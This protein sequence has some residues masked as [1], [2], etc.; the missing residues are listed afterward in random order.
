MPIPLELL[1]GDLLYNGTLDV[2]NPVKQAKY[3]QLNSEWE[4]NNATSSSGT[5]AGSITPFT[6]DQKAAET[7]AME[8][9][10]PYYEKLL[11]IYNGD[12]NLA[13]KRMEEDY[14]RG[15]RYKQEDTATGMGD[16][17]ATKEERA[18]KFQI[19]LGDLDQEMNTRGLYTSG[20][21]TQEREQAT[22]DETRQK[23]LL[24]NQARDLA[25]FEK[26]YVEGA[27]VEKQR[28]L[29][30]KGFASTGVEGYMSEPEKYKWDQ[31]QKMTEQ[32]RNMATERR[33]QK[34]ND[35]SYG[36]TPLATANPTNYTEVLN[37][38]LTIQGLPK[39]NI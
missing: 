33:S 38:A 15:L 19:A 14:S 35:W 11:K 31:A 37:N 10:R 1:P 13:K 36:V 4:R 21:R 6:F 7:A 16:I 26:R 32:S 20:I 3:N 8:E 30:E 5:A 24:E 39:V 17:N 23:Q 29:E 2:S 25:E 28:F 9:L 22:A 34:F 12:V 18:R 27:D